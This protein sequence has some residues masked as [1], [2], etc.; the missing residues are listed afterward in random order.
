MSFS[1]LTPNLLGYTAAV[2]S[3]HVDEVAVFGAASEGFSL[4]NINCSV[5]ESVERFSAVIDAAKADSTP[6]RGYISTVMGCP[7]DGVD[8]VKPITV[9]RLVER[10]LDLG[11]S[12]ISLGDTIGVGTAKKTR[13]LLAEVVSAVGGKGNMEQFQIAVHFHDTNGMANDNI[14]IAI[15]EFG[16]RVVDASVGGLGG[17]PYG[18][19]GATGNVSTESVCDTITSLGGTHGVDLGKLAEAGEYIRGEIKAHDIKII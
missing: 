8:S 13:E 19:D 6:V 9:A 14:R 2:A 7:Y 5:A 16:V 4:K 12:S 1:A 18:G 15:E 11:C 17:C 10:Y 3:L